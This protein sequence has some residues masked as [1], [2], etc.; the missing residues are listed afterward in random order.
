M[1]QLLSPSGD[2][3][4]VGLI[5]MRGLKM[6]ISR[7]ASW[8]AFIVL[9]VTLSSCST[10]RSDESLL[11]DEFEIPAGAKII[12]YAAFP[13]KAGWFGR[14][15]LK[16]DITFQLADGEFN[17]YVARAAASAKWKPLPIPEEFLRRMAAIETVKKLRIQSYQMRGE[18]LPQ[19][20]SVYNPT[21][22]QMLESFINSLPPQ[23][24]KGLFQIRAAGT[25]IMR[26]PKSVYETPNR[27]LNDFMLIILDNNQKQI[28][29]KVSTRY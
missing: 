10:P 1:M 18:V 27:D 17:E 29:I 3:Q 25:D 20:G 6:R 26:A 8:F 2:A 19:E 12:N 21:E 5:I 23:P 14:E 16:I 22:Q 15:G 4:A 24:A 13:E 28:M 7:N 9:L 11:R